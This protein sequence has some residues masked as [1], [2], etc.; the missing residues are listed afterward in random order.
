VRQAVRQDAASHAA[1]AQLAACAALVRDSQ[2]LRGTLA[3][4]IVMNLLCFGY[5]PLVPLVA[6]RFSVGAALAGVLAAAT[7]AGQI[8]CGLTLSTLRLSRHGLVFAAGSG[9]ALTGLIGF[10]V[11]P[12]F[13]L[14]VVALFL[15]GLGQGCFA[16]MQGLL[17]IES[18]DESQRGAVLGVLSTCI[19]ALPI[20]M[21]LMGCEAAAVGIRPALIYSALAGLTL[22]GCVLAALPQLLAVAR[23]AARTPAR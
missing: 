1:R 6:G 22:L 21:V 7:G 4:T 14:A 12:T 9:V 23:P 19:G 5:L 15:G 13:D 8:L 16:A 3:V 10:A 2:R 11:A 20:G 18:A 17:A